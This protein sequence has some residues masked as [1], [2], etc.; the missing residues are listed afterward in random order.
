MTRAWAEAG[1]INNVPVT[2][3]GRIVGML[4]NVNGEIDGAPTPAADEKVGSAMRPLSDDMLIEGGR[5]LEDF[6]PELLRAP[7]YRLVLRG[8]VIDAIVTPS[9]LNKLAVRVLAYAAVAHLE[10][11]MTAAIGALFPSDEAAVQEL[12]AGGAAQVLGDHRRL[13]GNRLNPSLLDVT[14]LKQKAVILAHTETFPGSAAEI[15][16]EFDTIYTELRNPLMH[17]GEYVTDSLEKLQ[18]FIDNLEVVSKRT[19]Q[20]A[21]ASEQAGPR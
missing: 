7:Y 18:Q 6:L 1:T 13:T 2:R 19:A 9:D 21:G 17:N 4:E 12:G 11:T 5:T 14:N 8:G 20:A 15:E 16:I 10:A 3:N